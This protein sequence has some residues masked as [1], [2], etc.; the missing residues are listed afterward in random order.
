MGGRGRAARAAQVVLVLLVLAGLGAGLAAGISS[1]LGIRTEPKVV[2]VETPV[3]APPR[4]AVPPPRL[5]RIDA[6]DTLRVRTALAELGEATSVKT[7]GRARLVVRITRA[8][9]PDDQDDTYRLSGTP[10]GSP[11]DSRSGTPSGSP[12]GTGTPSGDGTR[13]RITAATEAGAVRGIYDLARAAR[14]ARPLTER[15]GETVSSRLPFRMVDLGAAGVRPDPAE[16][17]G[18]ADYSHYSRAFADV[19]LP[20]APYIDQSRLPAARASVL[21]YAEHTLAQGYTTSSPCSPGAWRG[22]WASPRSS[23]SRRRSRRGPRTPAGR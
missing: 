21:E 9:A 18:G 23:A 20:E 22:S 17:A 11:S 2:P 8:G 3:P 12:S 16:W 6:P 4:E 14:A 1:A 13:L 19:L 5:T 10:S 15:L 7:R